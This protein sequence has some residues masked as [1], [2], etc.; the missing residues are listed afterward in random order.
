[1]LIQPDCIPCIIKMGLSVARRI[2]ADGEAGIM[3]FTR[4]IASHT[5]AAARNPA[6]IPIEVIADVWTALTDLT[7]EADLLKGVN[8][9]QNRVALR[10]CDAIRDDLP[11]GADR[12][13]EAVRL[14]IAAN[15][16]DVMKDAVASPEEALNGQAKAMFDS[17]RM[18]E[19]ETRLAR[20]R[21]IVYFSDNCGEI[22][23]DRLLIE[24]IRELYD[25]D[26]TPWRGKPPCST[27]R[28]APR[29]APWASIW[30]CRSWVTAVRGPLPGTI[31]ARVSP[32]VRSLVREA[33]L[34]IS[35][36]GGNHDALGE[37]AEIRGKVTFLFQAKCYP[38]WSGTG[39]RLTGSSS[40]TAD[41]ISKSSALFVDSSSPGYPRLKRRGWSIFD[42]EME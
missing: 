33:D 39:R 28:R 32:E 3:P 15:S 10:L 5:A 20:A 29:S 7:G 31:L 1:V 21:K 41:S 16:L 14:A 6:L 13:V 27:T 11:Q 8:V 36:G 35:K 38:Y 40:S 34:V 22:V 42:L 26:I 19:F 17:R 30:S 24:T 2:I 4:E 25:G 18:E 37:E 12:L 23:F 9:E